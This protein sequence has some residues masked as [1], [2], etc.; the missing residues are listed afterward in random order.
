M[1]ISISINAL[2]LVAYI[3]IASK[4]ASLALELLCKCYNVGALMADD[5]GKIDK[6]EPCGNISGYACKTHKSN[7]TKQQNHAQLLRTTPHHTGI[8]PMA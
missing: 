1:K 2:E 7:Q 3:H 5:I 8:I 4:I 6:I